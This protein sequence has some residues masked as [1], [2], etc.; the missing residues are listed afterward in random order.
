MQA[1]KCRSF[2]NLG[3][4]RVWAWR[5]YLKQEL[6]YVNK[7]CLG[8]I[9]IYIYIS[10]SRWLP[11]LT[12]IF[13]CYYSFP[14]TLLNILCISSFKCSIRCTSEYLFKFISWLVGLFML[15][16]INTI[17]FKIC[18]LRVYSR[19]GYHKP[20]VTKKKPLH[21]TSTHVIYKKGLLSGIQILSLYSFKSASFNS[22]GNKCS[23]GESFRHRCKRTFLNS[24]KDQTETDFSTNW[25]FQNR[26][27]AALVNSIFTP[28]K[29]RGFQHI[30]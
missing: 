24:L 5:D 13:E 9:T 29:L 16:T 6:L 17:I 27:K 4:C 8:N 23:K 26:L 30:L 10:E 14:F 21:L 25:S 3:C 22:N 28:V 20:T 7:E 1:V 18:I 12:C 19:D 2:S 11:G 15:L